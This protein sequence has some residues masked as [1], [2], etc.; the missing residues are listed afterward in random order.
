MADVEEEKKQQVDAASEASEVSS[1]CSFVTPE[2]NSDDGEKN[3]EDVKKMLYGDAID[4]LGDE[5]DDLDKVLEDEDL[6][7]VQDIEPYVDGKII[8]ND[9]DNEA[10]VL[11]E[12]VETNIDVIYSI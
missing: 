3:K 11:S 6:D 10:G 1:N 9:S 12:E 8:D 4:F 2:K 7:L 5:A